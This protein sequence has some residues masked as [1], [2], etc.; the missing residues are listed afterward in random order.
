MLVKRSLRRPAVSEHEEDLEEALEPTILDMDD[1]PVWIHGCETVIAGEED[2][3]PAIHVV[4]S[5]YR[6]TCNMGDDHFTEVN[7]FYDSARARKFAAGLLNA[8][9]MLDE[10]I[11][12]EE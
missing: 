8:A 11:A 5:A 2:G 3:V 7:H 12:S 9:D 4:I 10:Y 1:N 6:G